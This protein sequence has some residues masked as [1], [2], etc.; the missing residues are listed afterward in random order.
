MTGRGRYARNVKGANK[1][2]NERTK[3]LKEWLYAVV[4]LRRTC[5]ALKEEFAQIAMCDEAIGDDLVW[6]MVLERRALGRELAQR[7]LRHR[8]L[9]DRCELNP[10]ERKILQ[11]RY[12]QG[13]RWSQIIKA[14]G[15]SKAYLMRVHNRAL[16]KVSREC[17]AKA[18]Q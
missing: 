11:L 5:D 10:L 7:G 9:F 15:K 6:E 13:W 4:I 1:R 12:V 3:R 2:M 14:I 8:V 18:P 16:H 17:G